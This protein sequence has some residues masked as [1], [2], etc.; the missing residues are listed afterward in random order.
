[1]QEEEAQ[2]PPA[3]TVVVVEKDPPPVPKP[4]EPEPEPV[5]E[6]VVEEPKPTARSL[7]PVVAAVAATNKPKVKTGPWT[8]VETD[9]AL[10][11]RSRLARRSG[12]EEED[13]LFGKAN[14]SS[15]AL[16]GDSFGKYFEGGM[17]NKG[18]DG[19][20]KAP[21]WSTLDKKT[22]VRSYLPKLCIGG[23]SEIKMNSGVYYLTVKY[24]AGGA[25]LEDPLTDVD[26]AIIV[27]EIAFDRTGNVLASGAD[28]RKL[29]KGESQKEHED[30]APKKLKWHSSKVSDP[31]KDG[32]TLKFKIDTD[33]CSVG[34]TIQG[35]G[36]DEVRAG[37]MFKN[38][39]S[40]TNKRMYPKHLS[41]FA[42]CGGSSTNDLV[43]D[44]SFEGIG[45]YLSE[46]KRTS[47]SV[48]PVP[49]VVEEK[50][51]EK[52]VVVPRG[53]VDDDDDDDDVGVVAVAESEEEESEEEED[54]LDMIAP[55]IPRSAYT[56]PP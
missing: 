49:K 28:W 42:Y 47:R 23:E 31:W 15:D 29:F 32:D 17:R 9:V 24:E 37:W 36:D 2:R 52:P 30:V 38:V 44:I 45:F 19:E 51:E 21:K 39:L 56:P 33:T 43:K 55:V 35:K 1:M 34:F 11:R 54:D 3:T 20:L 40:F 5:E 7:P 10:K 50:V 12:S 46:T 41:V 14:E 13:S 6:E 26:A 48:L 25:I 18:V 4:K 16:S 53:I 8:L 27:G 22:C